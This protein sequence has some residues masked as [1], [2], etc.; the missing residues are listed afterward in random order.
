MLIDAATEF[1]QQVQARLRDD[2]APAGDKHQ[3]F[4]A[5]YL[6]TGRCAAW[7]VRHEDLARAFSVAIRV[8]PGRLRG[9]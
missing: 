4:K 3:G 9:S 5:K 6:D 2:Q 1:G 7:G 8:T